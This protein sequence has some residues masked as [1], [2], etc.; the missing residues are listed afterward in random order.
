M[1]TQPIKETAAMKKPHDMTISELCDAIGW[2]KRQLADILEMNERT[3]RRFDDP[4]ADATCP[5]VIRDWLETLASFHIAVPVPAWRQRARPQSMNDEAE[6][7]E[8]L[9]G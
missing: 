5:P 4:R 7:D 1:N 3:L 2:S 9:S 8:T 6:D